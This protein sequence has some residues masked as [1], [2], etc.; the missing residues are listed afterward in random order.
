MYLTTDHS[1]LNK[2]DRVEDENFV[3]VLHEIQRMV[4]IAPQKIKE[5]YQCMAYFFSSKPDS[6]FC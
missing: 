4:Q 5:R 6:V 1:G 2:F 3:L